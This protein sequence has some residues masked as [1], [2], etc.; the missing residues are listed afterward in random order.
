[1]QFPNVRDAATEAIGKDELITF[2][3][4]RDAF[5]RRFPTKQAV[6][7]AAGKKI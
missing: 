4:K 2:E 7:P 1:M 3:K 6:T 5:Q